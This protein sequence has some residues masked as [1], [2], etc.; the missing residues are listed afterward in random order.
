[1][2]PGNKASH[3]YQAPKNTRLRAHILSLPELCSSDYGIYRTKSDGSAPPVK[4]SFNYVAPVPIHCVATCNPG[5]R[6][7]HRTHDASPRHSHHSI[8][9]KDDCLVNYS[10]RTGASQ[11]QHV[12]D[13]QRSHTPYCDTSGLL[14]F[15][16][17]WPNTVG[18]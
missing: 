9:W 7:D 12:I 10:N 13:I 8:V 11:G 14:L 6:Q 2:A 17:H 1:M 3:V 16:S 5:N 4:R 15:H 18:R